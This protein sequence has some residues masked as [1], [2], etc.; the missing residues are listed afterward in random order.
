ME[1]AHRD[2]PATAIGGGDLDLRIERC[3]RH[4]HVARIGGD[5]LIARA[6]NR[7][8]LRN[9]VDRSAA[10]AR[11]ALVAG[12]V[13]IGE[14]VAPCPLTQVAAIRRFVAQLLGRA[15]EDCARQN[16]IVGAHA[17]MDRGFGIGRQRPDGESAIVGIFDFGE[18]DAIDVGELARRLDLQF[19][20]IE[21]VGAAGDG[22]RPVVRDGLRGIGQAAGAGV[23]ERPHALCSAT[24][25]MAATMLA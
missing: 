19:H 17:W 15:G 21:E 5:A 23:G 18:T 12:L 6:E 22:H 25:R 7:V 8:K 1:V 16:G 14:V 3:Q 20:Q 4:G 2:F 10:A 24:S 11:F 13:D 9:A